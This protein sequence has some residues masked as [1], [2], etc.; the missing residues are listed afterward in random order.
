MPSK[1]LVKELN[2]R[3]RRQRLSALIPSLYNIASMV[4]Q[5]TQPLAW[6]LR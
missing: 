3:I 4:L 1:T 2:P 6:S 5:L